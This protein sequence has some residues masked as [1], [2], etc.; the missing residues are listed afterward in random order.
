MESQIRTTECNR[1]D[2]NQRLRS[3]RAYL[4]V[5]DLILA[6]DREEYAGVAAG[7]AVLAGIAAADAICCRGLGKCFRGEDHRHAAELVRI[8]A[9]NGLLHRKLLLRLLD[10]KDAAHYGFSGLSKGNA[11]KAVMIAREM[12]ESADAFFQR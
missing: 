6:D 4:E 11:K 1:R 3:A 10:L 9:D 8:A 7:N 2:A 12:M 5:A